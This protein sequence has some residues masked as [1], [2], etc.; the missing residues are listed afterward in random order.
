M[1]EILKKVHLD[2]LVLG[3][4][5]TH[6]NYYDTPTNSA[7]TINLYKYNGM[8]VQETIKN[9]EI[10]SIIYLDKGAENDD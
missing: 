7:I 2:L 6:I 4:K 9:N 1:N 5:L 8:L 10:I 3:T